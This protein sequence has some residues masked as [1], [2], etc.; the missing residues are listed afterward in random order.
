MACRLWLDDKRMEPW[1][2]DLRART[3]REAIEM[4]QRHEVEHVSLDH[5]LADEHYADA[6]ESSPGYGEPP[7]PIDRS[8]YREPTGYAVI[9]WMHATGHWIADIAIH[10]RNSKAAEEMM[11][12][13]RRCA[14]PWVRCTRVALVRI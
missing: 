9:E 8:K 10:T 2:Y 3:A 5:D 4:I 7:R 13:V 6:V 11:A 14:P 12:K 1:G